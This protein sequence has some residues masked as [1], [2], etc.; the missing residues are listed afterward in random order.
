MTVSMT[1]MVFRRQM[2]K[3][4]HPVNTVKHVIDQQGGL[5][6][7]AKTEISIVKGVR[8]P[9]LAAVTNVEVGSHV[10]SIFLNIQVAASSTA[11]L[12]NIYMIIYGNP[13][14]NI[15]L[16]SIPNG[17]VVG[18]SDFKKNIFHQEMI[19]TEKNTT[20]IPRT[21][22]KGVLKIPRKFQRIGEDDNIQVS[23]YSP[24]VTWDFCLQSIYKAIM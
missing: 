21:L 17:N 16:G 23:L 20:A 15:A 9:A 7:D 14:A 10:R 12:A 24:G 1:T 4:L 13:G 3:Y 18:P 19:M 2:S 6:V 22:F 8:S 11:A 5:A